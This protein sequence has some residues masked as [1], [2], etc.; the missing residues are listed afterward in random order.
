[1]PADGFYCV[2]MTYRIGGDALEQHNIVVYMDNA[3]PIRLT[4]TGTDGNPRT[5]RFKMYVTKDPTI[6]LEGEG[7]VG[8][9]IYSL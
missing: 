6:Y 8:F 1:M 3:E 7:F 4:V 9:A 2:E 5:L